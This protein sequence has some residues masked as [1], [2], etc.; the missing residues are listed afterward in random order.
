VSEV[1][2]VGLAATLSITPKRVAD[3]SA[4]MGLSASLTSWREDENSHQTC[5]ST[6]MAMIF[7]RFIR[8]FSLIVR[9]RSRA[10]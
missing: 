9:G 8:D 7:G 3:Y 10:M 6:S 5:Q 2:H 1:S 4:L